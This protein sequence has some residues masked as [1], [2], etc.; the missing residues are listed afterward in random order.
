MSKQIFEIAGML[1]TQTKIENYNC[2]S[3]IKYLYHFINFERLEMI[4]FQISSQK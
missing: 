4:L 3:K 1:F 2:Y